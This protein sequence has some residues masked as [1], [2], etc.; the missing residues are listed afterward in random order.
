M[1]EEINIY[2]TRKLIHQVM[3][4]FYDNDYT[5][6][7]R[8]FGLNFIKSLRN[9][10]EVFVRNNDLSKDVRNNIFNFLAQ[11][12]NYKDEDFNERIDLINETIR[13][14]NSQEK[15]ESLMFYKFQ[16]FDRTGD[17]NFFFKAT[18]EEVLSLVD[19]IHD[20]ICNDLFV[21]ISHLDDVSDEE[22]INEYLPELKDSDSYYESIN[23]M[24]KENPIIF[25]NQTFYNRMICVLEYNGIMYNDLI[26]YNNK[27]V[28]KINKKIKKY[29]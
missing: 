26:N 22:F 20:S 9:V 5:D 16:L 3:F 21:L 14:L 23:Y 24:L 2:K 10:V 27:L 15:D 7:V 13:I 1:I 28:K 18:E 25:K 8:M 6:D 19:N 29:K 12:R 4:N 17:L 11:A